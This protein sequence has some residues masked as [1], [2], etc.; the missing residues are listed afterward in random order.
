MSYIIPAQPRLPLAVAV[1][2]QGARRKY[3]ELVRNNTAE[4]CAA[5]RCDSK[6]VLIFGG[7]SPAVHKKDRAY[8][9]KTAD[10]IETL[11]RSFRWHTGPGRKGGHSQLGL[12]ETTKEHLIE[13]IKRYP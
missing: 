3:L 10:W 1:W 5:L 12:S 13:E 11:P 7:C 6:N 2:L 8:G 9:L 4:R